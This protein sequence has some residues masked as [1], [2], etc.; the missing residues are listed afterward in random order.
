M[1]RRLVRPTGLLAEH[2]AL[3]TERDELVMTMWHAY[4]ILGF[5]T[6]GDPT[7]RAW[8]AGSGGIKPWSQSWLAA[9]REARKDHDDCIDE[10]ALDQSA[11]TTLAAVSELH[12][13]DDTGHA[14]EA[15][16]LTWPCKTRRTL[17]GGNQ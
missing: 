11:A 16:G 8:I 4:A 10:V 13:P 1:R 6:D 9:V 2:A 12:Q 5:D 15:D 7:P 3:E 17:D 14:C